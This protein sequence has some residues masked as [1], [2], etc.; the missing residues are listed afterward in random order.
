MDISEAISKRSST[1][2]FKPDTVPPKIL[3]EVM[4]QALR[5]PSWSNTQPWEFVIAGGRHLQEISRSFIAKTEAN[6]PLNPDLA[7]PLAYPEPFDSRRRANGR[8]L[9]EV[10]GLKRKDKEHRAMWNMQGLTMF[11]A[12][13]VIYICTERSFYQ[14]ENATNIWPVFDCGLVAQ[15]IMLLAMNYGL[16]TIP[17]IQSV[18]YPDVLRRVLEIPASKLIVLGIAVGYPDSDNP[19]NKFRSGREPLANIA[20]WYGFDR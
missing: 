1:R 16:G 4:E 13:C 2:A 20:K 7:I 5:A 6:E 11:E 10:I 3:E 12:P 17:E 8:A 14:Q 19:V 18:A 9:F 15:N